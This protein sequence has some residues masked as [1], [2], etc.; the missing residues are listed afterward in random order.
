MVF[1]VS[2]PLGDG[3][4]GRAQ[5]QLRLQENVS[6]SVISDGPVLVASCGFATRNLL[7]AGPDQPVISGIEL[8][9]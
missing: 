2:T 6:L 7:V 8:I 1:R 3:E 4:A 5:A 9:E